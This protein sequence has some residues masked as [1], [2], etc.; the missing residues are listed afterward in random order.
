MKSYITNCTALTLSE[1]IL[2]F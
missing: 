2:C 1:M